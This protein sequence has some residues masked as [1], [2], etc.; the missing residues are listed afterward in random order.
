MRDAA[1]QGQARQQ[2]GGEEARD[3]KGESQ[4]GGGEGARDDTPK[5]SGSAN[6][7]VIISDAWPHPSP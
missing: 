2:A 3:A 6:V 1:G 5:E 4:G 7:R